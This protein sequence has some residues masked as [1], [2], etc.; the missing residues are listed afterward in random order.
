[1]EFKKKNKSTFDYTMCS[2]SG[3][4]GL[5]PTLEIIDRT[6]EIGI[7]N[8]ESIICAWNL[9][10]NKLKKYKTKF[11]PIDSEHFSIWSLIKNDRLDKIEKIYITASGGPF[12]KFPLKKFN[13]INPNRALNHPNWSMGKKISIDSA[14]MMNKVFE[15]I[16]AKNLFDLNYNKIKAIIHPDSYVHAIVKFNNG[17]VKLLI[18]DTSMTIPIFNSIYLKDQKKIFSNPINFKKLNNLNFQ[19]IN[20][21]RYPVINVLKYIPNNISLFETVLIASND[22][23]VSLF[24]KKKIKFNEISKKLIQV[25]NFKEFI[26]YKK[27]KPKNINDILNLNN[28]VRLKIRSLSV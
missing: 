10:L 24:L 19:E 22:E 28:Y 3:I 8:K 1:I 4:D 13:Y 20:S 9:I 12:L 27:I 15:I 18:H 25:L 21:K 26:K 16:E 7:A 5:K 2:I 11:I 17:L 14:T 6:K 23:L